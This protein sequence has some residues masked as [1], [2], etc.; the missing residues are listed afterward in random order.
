MQRPGPF[1]PAVLRARVTGRSYWQARYSD[2]RVVSEW[3]RDFSLLNK[4]GMVDLRIVCPNGQVAGFGNTVEAGDRLFQLH[5]AL[6]Q[7]GRERR[8]IYQLIGL[9][10]GTDGR[11]LCFS[12]DYRLGRLVGPFQDNA[13]MMAY[14]Q[15]GAI[16]GEHLGVKP[17]S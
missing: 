4:R 7:A 15:I 14:E 11:C 9:I 5:G 2:G 1:D 17:S 6:L 8:T 3:E 10:N 12:Y 16:S 13:N